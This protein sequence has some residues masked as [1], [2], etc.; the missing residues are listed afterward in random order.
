MSSL[1]EIKSECQ[2]NIGRT[3]LSKSA[4]RKI[5]KTML[6]NYDHL[7]HE[8]KGIYLEQL[9][10]I[11]EG[12]PEI[13]P[14][15]TLSCAGFGRL[16]GVSASAGHYQR[17]K[18]IG[19]KVLLL[20]SNPNSYEKVYPVSEDIREEIKRSGGHVFSYNYPTRMNRN[21]VEE[22]YF[23]RLPDMLSVNHFFIYENAKN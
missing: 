22:K 14:Y 20:K 13:N 6:K 11:A 5:R 2:R 17:N 21:G 9:S 8:Q 3:D 16:F 19:A 4:I 12:Y 10:Y 18:M 7:L 1:F 23:L 15:I